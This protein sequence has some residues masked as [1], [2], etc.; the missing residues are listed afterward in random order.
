M[1]KDGTF[2]YAGRDTAPDPLLVSGEA[3]ISFG[4]SASRGNLVKSAKFDWAEAYLPY[5]PEIIQTPMNSIIGGASLWTMTAPNRTPA[6]YKA[7][8]AFLRYIGK[9]DVDAT[10]AQNTGYVPV[11]FAGY[12]LSKKQGYFEKNVGADI[13]VEQLARGTVTREHA[14]PAPRP[15]AGDPQH[16]PGGA[17]EGAAR[18]PDRPASAGC[19]RRPRQQGAEGVRQVREGLMERRTVFG[20]RLLPYLLVAPQLLLTFFFFY[21]PA[22]EAIWSSLT[23]EDAFG[24]G[25]VFVGL[26]NFLDLL[27]DPLYLQSAL[28]TVFFCAAVSVLSM[29]V[30]LLLAVFADRV[31]AGRTVYRTLLIW[32][33]AIAPAMSAVLFVFVLNPRIGLFGRWLNQHGIAWDYQLNGDAGD[34][35]RHRRQRLE[36]GQLQFHLFPRRPAVDPSFGD[37]GGAHGRCQRLAPVPHDDLSSAGAD[38]L[39]P[40]GGQ[41]R[42]CRVRYVRND[43]RADPGRT[44]EGYRDAGDQGVSR[45]LYQSGHRWIL[46]PVGDPD[47][48]GDRSDRVQFRFLGRRTVS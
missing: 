10:W 6:E 3:A 23:S 39:L 25:S 29:A 7:V 45:R 30:A 40:A 21:W 4:S 9:P 44:G 33:Y 22:G 11:T 34:G 24:Q 2:K 15:S 31:I 32:P 13:P 41:P 48:G 16:H 8:A 5:D 26:D 43:L 19:L 42:L 1:A 18:R 20:G 36:T 27:T 35:G 14:R 46:G 38:D 28:R 37:R 17:G 47:A 12:E